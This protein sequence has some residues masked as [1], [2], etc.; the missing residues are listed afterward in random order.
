MTNMVLIFFFLQMNGSSDRLFVWT[1]NKWVDG[2]QRKR[3]T[4]DLKNL[5]RFQF[6]SELNNKVTCAFNIRN[7]LIVATDVSLNMQIVP[8]KGLL[9]C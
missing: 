1:T 4:I 7:L 6:T 2:L 3:S 8:G 9:A 5:E